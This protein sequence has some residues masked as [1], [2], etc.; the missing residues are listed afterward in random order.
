MFDRWATAFS[1]FLSMPDSKK[2]GEHLCLCWR[3]LWTQVGMVPAKTNCCASWNMEMFLLSTRGGIDSTTS[4]KVF[5]VKVCYF[6]ITFQK[7]KP[8]HIFLMKYTQTQKKQNKTKNSV[9][10]SWIPGRRERG[11]QDCTDDIYLLWTKSPNSELLR[12]PLNPVAPAKGHPITLSLAAR[13]CTKA[14]CWVGLMLQASCSFRS[15]GFW[16]EKGPDHF[17]GF[18]QSLFKSWGNK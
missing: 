6:S 14:V 4:Q 15:L 8:I 10:R 11:F 2:E 1:P 17:C 18:Q 9:T 3:S 13:M 5:R 16:R 12:A 7:T